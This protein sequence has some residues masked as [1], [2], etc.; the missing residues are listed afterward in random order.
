MKMNRPT[1]A[2][3]LGVL[4]L[5]P[6]VL[7]LTFFV[8]A[9]AFLTSCNS[10]NFTTQPELIAATSG[11]PQSAQLNTAF[12][13]P[14]VATVTM[15]GTPASG[16][17][18]TFTA[19]TTGASGVFASTDTNSETDTTNSSGVAT[20]S[21]AFTANG[22]IGA[23][24][25]TASV[26]GVIA[27]TT[28]SLTNSA[29]P[30]TS[31]T[32]TSGSLQDAT[33]STAFE[34]PLVATVLD[35]NQNPVSGVSV[36]FTAPPSSGASGTFTN[37]TATETDTTGANGMAT[38]ST[39]TANANAGGYAITATVAGVAT[40][41][42]FSLTNITGAVISITPTSGTPQSATVNAAFATP[43]VAT[44]MANGSPVS[45]ATVTFEVPAAGASGTF[46]GGVNTAVTN[47][48]GMATSAPF[49]ANGSVGT[50]TVTATIASGA[51]PAN[52]ILTNAPINYAF[53]LSG[54]EAL[55]EYDGVPNFYALAGSVSVDGNGNVLGGEQDYNDGV[56]LNSPEPSP[57]IILPGPGALVVD[58][59]T[60]QGTLT[61]T[62][63]NSSLGVG[64][65]ETLA[66]QFV[67]LN[68]ALIVQ[69]DG[70]ATSSGSMDTQALASALNDGNYAFTLSG[71]D[72]GD[73]AVVYGGVFSISG[74][75]T[76]LTGTFDVD[77]FG[78]AINTPTLRT[79]FSG[80]I[81]GPDSMGRGS[82]TSAALAIQLNYYVVGPEA[83]RLIDVDNPNTGNATDDSA[84]GSAFGQGTGTFNNA[85]L[86]SSIFGVES[87]S[88]G[89][90]YAAAGMFTTD[91]SGNLTSGIADDNE[92][93]YGL[94]VPKAPISGSYTIM[95][96]GYG[97]LTITAGDLGDVSVLGMYM[98]DPQLNLN[99][100]NNTTPGLEGGALLADL[101][102]FTLNGTGVLTPQTDT[103]T[104]SFAGSYA[105]G[106]QA[107]NNSRNNLLPGW[108][109][110]LVGQTSV[111]SLALSQAT[112]LVSDPFYI[113]N[114]TT[115]G[116]DTATFS[117]TAASDHLSPGRYT[118][119]LGMALTGD[120][121]AYGTV[122]YQAAG[123]QLFW[124]DMDENG[125]SV[126]LGPLEQQGSL[127]GLPTAQKGGARTKLK[128]K[129]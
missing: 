25:V 49:T 16:A 14:L 60:G 76:A 52:F 62:T 39:F 100:P 75:G 9:L 84:I 71:V 2:K 88:L 40:P 99:D 128:R 117:G 97:S 118:I 24:T 37:G 86:G 79:P 12:S 126:F 30:A 125:D 68:H 22:T 96:N 63:N 26:A 91:G 17:F 77:D 13:A 7:A 110:D 108:E 82:I 54:L 120:D 103:S 129:P 44:V 57:D 20:T 23:Y 19:P 116:T 83:I 104:G 106:A 94:L 41:A 109:F 78:A 87:N 31:V 95:D 111:S 59:T 90:L 10:S 33:I 72:S 81:T 29:G 11:T 65:I 32:A 48:N 47:A 123:G 124:L 6:V 50:Y 74:G 61:L 122:I 42:D 56:G 70:S 119:T 27:T 46:A 5:A 58:P 80:T 107:Y 34:A 15:G 73:L 64:G 113:F 8:L 112:G 115:D 38:S 53:Y 43:L 1:Y 18:V 101:D 105:F 66:V 28:F 51:E 55:N 36:I 89:A 102:G 67:N 45:G 114:A 93:G 85:S 69:F 92:F 98:T 21:S 35:A 121:P 3:F 127:T 4:S